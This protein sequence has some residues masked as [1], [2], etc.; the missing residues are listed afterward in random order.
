VPPL[1]SIGALLHRFEDLLKEAGE[2]S[3]EFIN[4]DEG[5]KRALDPNN[6]YVKSEKPT[7]WDDLLQKRVRENY[8]RRKFRFEP[9]SVLIDRLI[10]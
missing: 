7:T 5:I 9:A 3:T 6:E 8:Y 1:A 10:G 2:V 4:T